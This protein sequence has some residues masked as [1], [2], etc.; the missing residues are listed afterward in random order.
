MKVRE[1]CF[2]VGF[3]CFPALGVL[4][5]NKLVKHFWQDSFCKIDATVGVL[6]GSVMRNKNIAPDHTFEKSDG[7]FLPWPKSSFALMVLAPILRPSDSCAR[8]RDA[9]HEIEPL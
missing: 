7:A 2:F 6:V 4:L 5:Q 9:S 8:R 1:C 3:V